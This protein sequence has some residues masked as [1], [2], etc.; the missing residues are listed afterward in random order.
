MMIARPKCGKSFAILDLALALASGQRWLDFYVQKRI[1]TALVSREDNYG[2]TQ[3]RNLKLS[4]HRNLT[5]ADLDGWLYINAKGLKPKIM[6]DYPDDVATL[7]ADLK[8]YQ[9]EFLIL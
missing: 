1:R 2:L 6:L 9:T 8:R 3:W 4:K 7:V 5:P